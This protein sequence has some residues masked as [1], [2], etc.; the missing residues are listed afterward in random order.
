METKDSKLISAKEKFDSKYSDQLRD[1]N[2]Y[3]LLLKVKTDLRKSVKKDINEFFNL[4]IW[5]MEVLRINSEN[6]SLETLMIYTLDE[7][8]KHYNKNDLT[9]FLNNLASGF[10]FLPQVFDKSRIKHRI[11]KF[12]E[13]KAV[14]EISI[15]NIG[16]FKLFAYDSL[17][18]KD[19]VEGLRYAL[20][21]QDLNV[22]HD[23]VENFSNNFI[24]EKFEY[25]FF[26]SRV[27]LEILLMKN[28]VLALNFIKKYIDTSNNLQNNAPILNFA[29]LLTCLLCQDVTN[30]NYFWTFINLYRPLVSLDQA[31]PKYLNKVSISFYGQEIIKEDQGMN[32]MNLLK[33]F[34]N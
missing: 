7:Y 25:N 14:P 11:L 5:S 1:K 10:N 29:Y 21:S 9:L 28:L 24:K 3:N 32:I 26:V 13:T 4:F 22:I 2:F 33:A 31:F 6:E 18:N 23:Y 17:K 12:F 19:T 34:T 8:E 16:I 27:S 20:K 15:I 30:F